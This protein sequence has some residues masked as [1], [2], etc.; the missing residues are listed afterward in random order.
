MSI[1]ANSGDI[2]KT[3]EPY[4]GGASIIASTTGAGSELL[5]SLYEHSSIERIS[6]SQDTRK[7]L[8]NLFENN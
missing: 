6:H 5:N 1:Y 8:D 4:I 7:R 2:W 3:N